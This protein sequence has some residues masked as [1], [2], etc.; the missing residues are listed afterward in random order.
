MRQQQIPW[1]RIV[2]EGSVIV[3]SILLALGADAAWEARKE[4]A[5]E[6]NLLTGLLEEFRETRAIVAD[7]ADRHER[8]FR[9]TALQMAAYDERTSLD[10]TA[11]WR[12]LRLVYFEY[13]TTHP[14]SGVLDG[15]LSTGELDK[16]SDPALRTALA[17]W[18]RRFRE[19]REQE[20]VIERWVLVA[21]P[22]L[23]RAAPFSRQA[24]EYFDGDF[25]VTTPFAEDLHLFLGT[26]DAKNLAAARALYEWHAVRDAG[27]LLDAVDGILELLE[28]ELEAGGGPS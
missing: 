3:V 17:G 24:L 14:K 4:L 26:E 12:T 9:Q 27:R 8:V 18:P 21:G 15:M 20:A 7:A 11:T 2:A 23:Y 13:L 25:Q 5:Q 16:L 22:E 10:P 6:R 28:S 1:A 19:F